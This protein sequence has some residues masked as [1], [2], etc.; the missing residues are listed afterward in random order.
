MRYDLAL[1]GWSSIGFAAAIAAHR[2]VES[3]MVDDAIN[4]MTPDGSIS[5]GKRLAAARSALE[6][7]LALLRMVELWCAAMVEATESASRTRNGDGSATSN[8]A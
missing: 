1:K 7:E 4:A 6:N 8:A 2:P 5:S 3:A